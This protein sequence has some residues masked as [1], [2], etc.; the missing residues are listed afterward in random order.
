MYAIGELKATKLPI[1]RPF[2]FLSLTR[3]YIYDTFGYRTIISGSVEN[4]RDIGLLKNQSKPKY[5]IYVGPIE[6]E[7][8][9]SFLFLKILF[10]NASFS[11]Y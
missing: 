6:M 5:E 2:L 10:K 7:F 3:V 11:F 1:N 4:S 9:F 8:P